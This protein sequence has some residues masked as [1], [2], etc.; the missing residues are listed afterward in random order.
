[1]KKYF[2]IFVVA[3]VIGLGFVS[4][5]T[6]TDEPAGGTAVEKMA[7]H[8][9]ANTD[10]LLD[11][12]DDNG[13]TIFLGDTIPNVYADY[14]IVNWPMH[15]YNTAN[16]DPDTIWLTDNSKFWGYTIKVP[17]D[18]KAMTFACDSVYI[19]TAED[20][21]GNPLDSV[22]CT[23]TEGKVIPNGGLNVNGKPTDAIQ[24][25][26]EFTDDPGSIYFVHGVRYAG[27]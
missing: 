3:L 7:G 1:M 19:Y 13:D 18:V 25:N 9:I 11:E 4:C 14:G 22:F 10:L 20:D 5:S 24:Y 15:T 27:F 12:I 26:I 23:I 2:S 16:N 17:V 6:E 8:W 21:D